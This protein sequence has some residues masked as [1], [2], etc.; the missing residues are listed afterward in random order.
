M[1]RRA[2]VIIPWFGR[3]PR[4]FQAFVQSAKFSRSL[5]FHIFS[6]CISPGVKDNVK[7]IH[8]SFDDMIAR[9]RSRLG[10]AVNI[11][12]PYKLCDYKPM[13]A[14]VFP[15]YISG[16]EYWGWGDIDVIYGDMDGWLEDKWGFDVVSMRSGWLSGAFTLFRNVP[17]INELYK[18]SLMLD[19][20]C[21]SLGYVNFDELAGV[22]SESEASQ[23]RILMDKKHQSFTA[24][25]F[26][27]YFNGGISLS[28]TDAVKEKLMG[29]NAIYCAD[30]RVK[31]RSGVE[32]P[33]YHLVC[34]KGSDCFDWADGAIPY[35]V[36]LN[37]WGFSSSGWRMPSFRRY[38]YS[39]LRSFYSMARIHFFKK[40]KG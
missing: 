14:D 24:V 38:L 11:V 8:I 33:L 25:V 17:E 1:S 6:D 12:H 40:M 10:R 15:E 32:H 27:E 13:L 22:F 30:G 9:V 36:Y 2:A 29:R 16:Y 26:R 34:D 7:V 3:E 37:K 21:N 20:V 23:G 39:V 35:P 4:Y 5:D 18:K 28:A 31:D 19:K